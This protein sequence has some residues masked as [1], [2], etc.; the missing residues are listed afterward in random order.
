MTTL[1]KNATVYIDNSFHRKD[2]LIDGRKVF[3][4]SISHQFLADVVKVWHTLICS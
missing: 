4:D 1:L 3:V 2:V